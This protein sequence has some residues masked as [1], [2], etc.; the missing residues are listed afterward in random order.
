MTQPKLA[1]FSEDAERA[2]IGAVL[3][4]PA[5]LLDVARYINGESF[6]LLR[7]QYIFDALMRISNR[8]QEIDFVSVVNELREVGKLDE[9]GGGAYLL[10]LVNDTPTSQ[11]AKT[12][13]ELV[14][15][16]AIRR[17]LL[18]AGDRLKALA[19]EESLEPGTLGVMAWAAMEAVG[20]EAERN[21]TVMGRDSIG[22]YDQILTRRAEQRENGELLMIPMPESWKRLGAVVEYVPLG[23]TMVVSGTSGSGKSAFCE[24]FAEHSAE[25]GLFTDYIHT[26]MTSADVLDR[27]AAR[28]SGVNMR[29][30]ITGDIGVTESGYNPYERVI[31]GDKLIVKWADNIGY[32]YMPNV[33]FSTLQMHLKR[34]AMMGVKVFVIDHFQ[35]IN[36]PPPAKGA[37]EI[38][39]IEAMIVWLNAFAEKNNVLVVIASQ[40]NDAGKVKWSRKLVEKAVLWLNLRRDRLKADMAYMYNGIEYVALQ[41]EDSP[42]AWIDVNKA[43]FGRKAKIEMLYHG[44]G[45][46]WLDASQVRTRALKVP[47]AVVIDFPSDAGA[48]NG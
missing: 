42:A 46:S 27:R 40:L 41:G 5:K 45:F 11:H 29:T 9:I 24:Q 17:R 14:Q 1:P 43:R 28:Y 3:V 2:V 25:L 35:D 47:A 34:A 16:A 18:N 31:E 26:E 20:F 6:Y 36:P 4:D 22:E 39:V 10:Q 21:K 23:G 44:A 32:H 48:A 15:R 7:H 37:N 8:N 13:A 30:L 38:R 33:A 19:L 12:Y